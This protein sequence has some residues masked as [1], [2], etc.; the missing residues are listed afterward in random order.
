MAV[1]LDALLAPVTE[2]EDLIVELVPGDDLIELE[3]LFLDRFQTV[4][5][6]RF[7]RKLVSYNVLFLDSCHTLSSFQKV[8]LFA[9]F[10]SELR[11]QA[12]DLHAEVIPLLG[13]PGEL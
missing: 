7:F 10:D 9:S 4:N 2:N 3:V 13:E 11:L 12:R 5:T 8:F 6:H 1:L